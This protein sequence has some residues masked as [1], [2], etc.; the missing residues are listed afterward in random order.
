MLQE[1]GYQPVIFYAN[2]NIAPKQEYQH[3]L[4]TLQHWAAGE[5]LPVHEG[6]YDPQAWEDTAGRIGTTD[7]KARCRACYRLRLEESARFA[8][9]NG[10]EALGTTLTVSIYQYTDIIREELERACAQ[11]GLAPV[12]DDFRPYFDE[13]ERRSKALGMYRQNY[14]GCRFSAV[15][16][17]QER[18]ERRRA[19]KEQKAAWRAEHADELAAKEAQAAAKRAEK[20]AYAEK[21]R[22]KREILKELRNQS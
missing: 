15:E 9:E 6:A 12:F 4:E 2:S 10:F 22:R 5:G 1:R 3:R 7:R 16:A 17:E 18:A 13:A 20:A 11:Y 19:I 14:C 21:Q 8:A